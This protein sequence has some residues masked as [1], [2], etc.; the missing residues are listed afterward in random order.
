[1]SS[2][3]LVLAGFGFYHLFIYQKSPPLVADLQVLQDKG[4]KTTLAMNA[5]E[6]VLPSRSNDG[7]VPSSQLQ[8]VPAS[9]ETLSPLSFNRAAEV[10][11]EKLSSENLS[12]PS[13]STAKMST[14]PSKTTLPAEK[15]ASEGISAGKEINAQSR[16]RPISAGLSPESTSAFVNLN[17]LKATVCADIKDR[18]PAGVGN[19][20]PWSTHR[21]YVWS[22]VEAE[23]LP[24]KIRHIYYLE[25]QKISDVALNVRS[26]S[27]RTW[28]YKTISNE[29]YKGPWRVDI[30]SA[31]G[32]VLQSLYFEVN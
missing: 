32:H 2:T 8:K 23:H 3:I 20:F 27:W 7:S 26:S 11:P 13:R 6:N 5:E 22:L 18:M 10:S 4:S 17:V 9:V 14:L 31:E 24:S 15:P 12:K 25:G 29:R 19:S 28:S 16:Q 1:L 21:V 30:A